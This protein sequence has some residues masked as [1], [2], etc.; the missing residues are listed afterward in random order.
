VLGVPLH[1]FSTNSNACGPCPLA[2]AA[3]QAADATRYPDASYATLR[4][5]LAAFHA[6]APWRIVLAGSASEF[7]FRITAWAKAQG[8][9]TVSLPTHAY[10]D[11]AHAAQAWGL[12]AV[13]TPDAA[14]LVWA[15]EPSSPLG[16]VH[17]HWPQWLVDS[18]TQSS[19]ALESVERDSPRQSIVASQLVLDCAYA[20]LRLGGIAS[21]SGAQ[22]DAVWQ[23]FSPNK[24]L[25]LTGVRAAYAIAPLGADVAVHKLN[26]MAPSWVVGSHGV[27]L[28]MAWTQPQVQA[29]LVHSVVRLGQWKARQIEQL[30][31]LGWTCLPSEANYFCARPPHGVDASQLCARLRQQGLKLRDATSFGLSGWVRL[32]VLPPAAQDALFST[33]E[34]TA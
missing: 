16:Q 2:L 31:A 18:P 10:G 30:T 8:A 12:K 1:D 15:C 11:Y 26:A 33:L 32:G 9:C 23:L 20:P 25:G 27:A 22:R 4:A 7:I 14:D 29:W 21:L 13:S 28:L 24:S 19:P 17:T 34:T 6:V 3:V 5:A